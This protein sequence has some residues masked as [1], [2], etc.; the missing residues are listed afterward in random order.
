MVAF[1]ILLTILVLFE[2]SEVVIAS[3]ADYLIHGAPFVFTSTLIGFVVDKNYHTAPVSPS[4]MPMG[5]LF[6]AYSTWP[7][8]TGAFFRTLLGIETPFIATPKER[9][10][11]N[12][13]KLVLPQM[14][15]VI[16]LIAAI[17]WRVF[18]GLD[19][20]SAI[21]SIFGLL[22]IFMHSGAFYA[23]W[24]GWRMGRHKI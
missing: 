19:Y 20:S 6:L 10:G 7:V 12:F 15:T 2:G 24:E 4:G 11:G 22:H 13:L 5:G 23:V 1:H 18:H 17:G 8:Y 3:F 9:V 21:I 16:L 14:I